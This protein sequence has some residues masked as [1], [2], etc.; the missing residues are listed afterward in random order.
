MYLAHHSLSR[1]KTALQIERVYHM[2]FCRSHLFLDFYHK[3]G[4]SYIRDYEYCSLLILSVP[5]VYSL[6]QVNTKV[7]HYPDQSVCP[8]LVIKYLNRTDRLEAFPL[9]AHHAW[10]H[11]LHQQSKGSACLLAILPVSSTG[12]M[13][14]TPAWIL[15]TLLSS[16]KDKSPP[17]QSNSTGC[18]A[19]ISFA[20]LD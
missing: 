12:R 4:G 11:S 7:D 15:I 5:T 2:Y 8:G 1:K 19:L 20:E 13:C 14:S 9:T 16:H 17:P 6:Q 3:H 10:V 18:F